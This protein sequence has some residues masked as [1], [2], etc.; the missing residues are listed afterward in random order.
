[1]SIARQLLVLIP[2]AFLFSLSGRLEAVWWAFPCSELVSL[3][4]T[5]VFLRRVLRQVVA[6]LYCE[7]GRPPLEGPGAL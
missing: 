4:L 1:M 5:L 6:P 7:A 3:A 2:L